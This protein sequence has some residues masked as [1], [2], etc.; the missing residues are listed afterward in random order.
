MRV[1]GSEFAGRKGCEGAIC[2]GSRHS[3]G[4]AQASSESLGIGDGPRVSPVSLITTCSPT[5]VMHKI[6][7][8]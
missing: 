3:D 2:P 8:P 7:L 1:T 5:S 6:P 4:R